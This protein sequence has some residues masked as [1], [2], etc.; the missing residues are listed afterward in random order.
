MTQAITP[1][2]T[3]Y[4]R[5]LDLWLE[6]AI[7]QLKAGDFH[8]LDV[9]NLIEELEGLSGSN[10]RE[11]ETRLKRL[12]EHIL[13]RCYVNM[14]ECFRGWE[15]T[16]INQ[17][18]ELQKLLKQSPSLKRHFSKMFDDSFATALKIVRTEYL[19]TAF[20]ETW[21]F[22]RDIDTMLNVDFWE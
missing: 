22:N 8:N 14:P 2:I 10:K 4:E 6:T 12:I 17:R 15:V 9:E 18:D 16:I 7:A 3:L 20:P 19:E 11:V 13:K 21:Q 1:S 5:D